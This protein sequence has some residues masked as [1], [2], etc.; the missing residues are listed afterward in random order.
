M[1]DTT[2]QTVSSDTGRIAVRRIDGTIL[3]IGLD[4]PAKRNG[5]TPEMALQLADA[6][7][8]LERDD[9]LRVGVLYAE[10]DHFTGGLDLPRWA[11]K[12]Q[13]GEPMW[14]TDRIDPFGLREPRRTK[15]LVCAVQGWCWTL[16][17]ELMM[18]ADIAVA[19][20]DTRFSQLE[21]LR[22][23]MATGGGTV[24]IAE[25]AGLSNALLYLLTGDSFDAADALRMG[26]VQKLVPAGTQFDEA[27]AIARRIAAAAPLAVRATLANARL[28]VEHGLHAAVAEHA[29]VQQ[30]LARSEDAAEGVAAFTER[31]APRFQGR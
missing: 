16:G 4:R 18:A 27:L 5:F 3:A 28:A 26:L 2:A 20:H 29:S 1:T 11:P 19:A 8:E 15:P 31:R 13:A 21:V 23:V 10:G 30:G 22:G 12:M 25:R 17:L 24:R 9:T 7:T 14:P 6:Y